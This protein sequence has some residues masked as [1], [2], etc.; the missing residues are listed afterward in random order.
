M[1]DNIFSD[2]VQVALAVALLAACAANALLLW[3]WL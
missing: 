3:A 2:G 1:I